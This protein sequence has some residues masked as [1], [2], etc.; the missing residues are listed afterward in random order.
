MQP[1]NFYRRPTPAPVPVTAAP[2]PLPTPGP[3]LAL[4]RSGQSSLEAQRRTAVQLGPARRTGLSHP[5]RSRTMRRPATPAR[6]G[7]GVRQR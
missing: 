7:H 2:K 5:Y 4:V 1:L 6:P 3:V